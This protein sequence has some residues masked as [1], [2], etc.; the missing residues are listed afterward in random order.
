MVL[1]GLVHGWGEKYGPILHGLGLHSSDELSELTDGE[2]KEVLFEPLQLGGAPALHIA[3]ILKALKQDRSSLGTNHEEDP[4]NSLVNADR[5]Y[6][7]N[8]I[9]SIESIENFVQ[10]VTTV[11]SDVDDDATTAESNN[12][13]ELG[14]KRGTIFDN[15]GI[16]GDAISAYA[17]KHN[18]HVR[19]EKHAIVCS[20][21]GQTTWTAVNDFEARAKKKLRK[22]KKS[23]NAGVAQNSEDVHEDWQELLECEEEQVRTYFPA[24]Y[25]PQFS[26]GDTYF[27]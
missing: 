3:R 17:L 19:R 9:D 11:S 26:N 2:V 8:R 10:D 20:N 22:L 27:H 1:D 21:A 5:T 25:Y 7:T 12:E 24:Q 13:R 16:L 14:I 23:N 15:I 4:V 6:P 18:F